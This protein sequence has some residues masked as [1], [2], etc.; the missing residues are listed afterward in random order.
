MDKSEH[1][2]KEIA[3][4]LARIEKT[5]AEILK[6]LKRNRTPLHSIDVKAIRSMFRE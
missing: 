6:E 4:S 2:L 3:K 5:N 1:Y